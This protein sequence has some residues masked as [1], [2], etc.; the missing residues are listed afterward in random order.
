GAQPLVRG[1]SNRAA[2]YARQREADLLRIV[3]RSTFS[4]SDSRDYRRSKCSKGG[5]AW[6]GGFLRRLMQTT[7]TLYEDGT[8]RILE[9]VD[10]D[11]DVQRQFVPGPPFKIPQGVIKINRPKFQ[12]Q[13]FSRHLTYGAVCVPG[14]V[15]NALFLGLGAGIVVQAV[16]DLFPSAN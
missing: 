10:E 4:G 16:R 14:G 1:A 2:R 13:P 5:F 11:G 15:K 3:Q 6:T 9:C 7:Q 12:V 8:M